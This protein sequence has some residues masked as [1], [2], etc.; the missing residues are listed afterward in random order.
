MIGVMLF[1]VGSGWKSDDSY[2]KETWDFTLAA[3]H[4]LKRPEQ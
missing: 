4:V 2:D 1:I 3:Q